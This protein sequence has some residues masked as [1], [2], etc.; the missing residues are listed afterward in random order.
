[1]AKKKPLDLK[2]YYKLL[3]VSVEAGQDEIRLATA[4]A[5]Q[6]A[7]GP[8]LR[9]IEE[10][11][12]VLSVPKRRQEY[13]A[14][15]HERPNP[16]KSPWTLVACIAILIGVFLWLY[17]PEIAMHRKTF[18]AGQRL[19]DS[20]TRQEFGTVVQVDQNHRFPNGEVRVGYLVRT[21]DGGQDRWYPA[22]D[23]QSTVIA[24]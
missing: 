15:G 5:K 2:G 9:R 20:R 14:L 8:Y 12:G 24:R 19:M 23:L 4:I 6:N 22:I 7:A 18:S 1:M 17:A 10:A 11:W 16:L 21:A 3:K 13:D